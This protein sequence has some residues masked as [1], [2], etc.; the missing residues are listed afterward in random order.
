VS[1]H[2]RRHPPRVSEQTF[3]NLYVW[4]YHRPVRWTEADGTLLFFESYGGERRVVGPPVGE[5]DPAGL[6][7]DLHALGVTSFRRIPRETADALAEAGLAVE[8]DRDNFDYVCRRRDLAELSGRKYHRQQN[9]VNR[10]LSSY[11]C[12]YEE[13]GRDNA[14]EVAQMIDR[15]FEGRELE[16]SPGLA[17]EYWAL[18]ETLENCAA[19]ELRGG[20][21][22]VDGRIEA[23]SLGGRLNEDTAVVHFEKAMTEFTGLYQVVNKWFCERGLADFE[24]VN[25][26][27]D[28]G[29]PGLRKAKE[30][31]HPHHMVEKFTARW[32]ERPGE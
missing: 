14:D 23:F 32:P 10:C 9:L 17:Q 29:I 13:L 4:R 8:A 30:S 27:Q 25:R 5:A 1:E 16:G 21:V 7:E 2:L 12:A 31:Y 28:L 24:F 26:E 15:W 11:N 22:R 19:F 6:L 20:A 3:C 18:R